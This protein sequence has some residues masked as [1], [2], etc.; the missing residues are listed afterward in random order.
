MNS[1][2]SVEGRRMPL[3]FQYR[4]D[5]IR[6]ALWYHR[7]FFI[8]LFVCD[9]HQIRQS[10]SIKYMSIYTKYEV[11]VSFVHSGIFALSPVTHN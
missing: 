3:H 5:L 7:W 6:L 10:L 11:W 1:L 4:N 9:L 2:I 8:Y